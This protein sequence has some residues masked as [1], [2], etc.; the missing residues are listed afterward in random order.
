MPFHRMITRDLFLVGVLIIASSCS[1]RGSRD[2]SIPVTFSGSSAN[3]KETEILHSLS[4]PFSPGKNAIWCASFQAAWKAL[5]EFAGE[6]IACEHS[7]EA[8]RR[9]NVEP[10]P[11]PDIPADSL[12]AAA[13]RAQDGIIRKIQTDLKHRFPTKDPPTFPGLP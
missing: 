6:P 13:G 2:A 10:D 1:D 3:L 11:R 9:L 5:E 12:Y 4:E 8:L 7:P